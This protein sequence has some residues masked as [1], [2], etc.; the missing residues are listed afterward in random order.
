MPRKLTW[1]GPRQIALEPY[2]ESPL[3]PTQLRARALLSGISHGTELNLYRGTSPFA[4]KH[5][6]PELRLF[7]PGA[8]ESAVELGYEWVG[9]VSEVG[10]EVK[11]LHVGDLVHLLLPHQETQTVDPR[12]IPFH[13]RL[14][15]LPPNLS[16]DKAIF[17]A[18]AGVAL[19]A[20]HDAHI[21]TGD[22]VAI[23][24]LGAIGLLAVQLARLN[25]AT[26]IDAVDLFSLRRQMARRYGADRTLDPTICDVGYEIKSASPYRGADVAI[27][28]SGSYAALHEAIRCVRMGGTVVTGGFY[29]GG[30]EA[31]RLGEEWHHN[32]II[33]ISSMA[34]WQCPHRDHPLWDRTRIN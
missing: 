29:Q 19:Q 34:A 9:R 7:R 5:F 18:L 32:R 12:H 26:W 30:G 23:F 8:K 28:L 27:E 3:A 2:D 6:D 4:N 10:E 15:A 31:L 24:G 11:N 16:P 33:L 21:K 25:G 14:E 1:Q 20:I 13:R 22:R 17:L